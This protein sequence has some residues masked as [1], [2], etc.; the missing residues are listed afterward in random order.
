MNFTAQIKVFRNENLPHECDVQG[1]LALSPSDV[2]R[3][4]AQGKAI[5]MHSLDSMLYNAPC[6]DLNNFPMEYTRGIDENTLY[7]SSL[8]ARKKI[9]DYRDSQNKSMST[10]MDN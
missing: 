2:I 4:T 8:R 7:E 3:L 1:N 9:R 10:S 6:D 5:A